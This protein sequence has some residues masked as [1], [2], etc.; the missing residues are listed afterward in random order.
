[1]RS[2]DFDALC[3]STSA[4]ISNTS[5]GILQSAFHNKVPWGGGVGSGAVRWE[6]V[7]VGGLKGCYWWKTV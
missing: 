2:S 5:N 4:H 7:P 6:R 1:M 3:K